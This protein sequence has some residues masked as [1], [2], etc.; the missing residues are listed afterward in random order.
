MIVNLRPSSER[1]MLIEWGLAE[2]WRLLELWPH[3]ELL[4]HIA[5][6]SDAAPILTEQDGTKLE[7]AVRYLRG[8]FF[9]NL[10]QLDL[11]WRKGDLL[12]SEMGQVTFDHRNQ[13][14]LNAAPSKRL[15]DLARCWE[16]ITDVAFVGRLRTM[17]SSF[18][19]DRMRGRPIL[20]ATDLDAR[21]QLIEGTT[22]C[23]RILGGIHPPMVRL[24][25]CIG[26]GKRLPEWPRY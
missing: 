26:V 14:F 3:D 2:T 11:V 22:R 25:V 4:N 21:Y 7:R 12:T 13:D 17:R 15:D 18:E 16:N 10:L 8:T 1:E 20:V 24:P 23:L 6:A 19:R 5:A 9:G